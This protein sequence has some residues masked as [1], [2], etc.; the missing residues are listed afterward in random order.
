MAAKKKARPGASVAPGK[1]R[2]LLEAVLEQ[3]SDA[4][5]PG[6]EKFAQLQKRRTAR[7][8]KAEKRL[9]KVLGQQNPRVI[10]LGKAAS[11]ASRL[12]TEVSVAAKRESHKR[13][14]AA[15]EW[16]IFGEVVDAKG[17]PM[18]GMNVQ[19][20]N[21]KQR[22]TRKKIV[23]ETDEFG[24]FFLVLPVEAVLQP[25][26]KISAGRRLALDLRLR[27]TDDQGVERYLSTTSLTP[28]A[29][30]AEYFKITLS[31]ATPRGKKTVQRKKS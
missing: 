14:V 1:E 3:V 13:W 21:K 28:H 25:A 19:L 9:E 27:I 20:I 24:D 7:M 12:H 26:E 6:L 15:H 5:K 2:H 11:S 22:T 18:A 29:G 10:A 4:R 8:R 23:S 17:R 30:H 16:A 31:D